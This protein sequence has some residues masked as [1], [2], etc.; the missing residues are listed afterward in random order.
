MRRWAAAFSS[1][2]LI[3]GVLTSTVAA[4]VAGAIMPESAQMA[5]C[6]AGHRECADEGTPA[7]CC[8]KTEPHQQQLIAAKSDPFQA[9]H[10]HVLAALTPVSSTGVLARL[11]PLRAG[12]NASPPSMV[13]RPAYI[14]L[15]VLLI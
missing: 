2:M 3:V 7:D 15:S 8:K 13:R 10:R 12:A 11:V 5:C 14:V 4:C 6:K 9:P 1:G